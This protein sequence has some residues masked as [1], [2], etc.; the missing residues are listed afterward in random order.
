M[1][2]YDCEYAALAQ[3]LSVEFITFDKQ[4]IAAGLGMHPSNFLSSH[5]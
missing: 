1:A 2:I 3:G 5:D 4:V